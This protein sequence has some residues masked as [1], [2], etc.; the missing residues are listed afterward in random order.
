LR[1]LVLTIFL[2]DINLAAQFPFFTHA[3]RSYSN[4]EREVRH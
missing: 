1:E 3:P 4:G 2:L